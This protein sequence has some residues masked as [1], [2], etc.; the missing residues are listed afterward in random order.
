MKRT[1]DEE[2]ERPGPERRQRMFWD[3]YLQGLMDELPHGGTLNSAAILSQQD[4]ILWTKSPN[5]PAVTPEQVHAVIQAFESLSREGHVGELGTT[6]MAIGNEKFQLVRC[7]DTVL[8]G[9]SGNGGCTVKRTLTALVV[10][11]YRQH[12][13][14]LGP[15]CNMVVETLGDRLIAMQC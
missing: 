14:I 7:D 3:T 13:C 10:G 1:L 15:D 9:I 2:L 5:F 4:A 11:I 12:P 8:R 6:G